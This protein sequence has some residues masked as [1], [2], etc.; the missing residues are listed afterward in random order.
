LT[1]ATV[2]ENSSAESRPSNKKYRHKRII[3][4]DCL[5]CGLLRPISGLFRLISGL[6]RL[7]SGLFRPI[8]GLFRPI[9]G[10]FRPI[11]GLICSIK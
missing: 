1:T 8:N 6:F 7:I 3:E 4:K 5:N 11:S 10:L 2:R 9:N